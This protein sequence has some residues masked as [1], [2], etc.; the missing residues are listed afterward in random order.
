MQE[1]TQ[2]PKEEQGSRANVCSVSG[3]S[4]PLSP[5]SINAL[6]T[7]DNGDP[8]W[9]E[10]CQEDG[11]YCLY[12]EMDVETVRITRDLVS[13]LINSVDLLEIDF[14]GVKR[15]DSAG[16]ALL[17]E[18]VRESKKLKKEIRYYNIPEQLC[19]IARVSSLE[20]VLPLFR[21]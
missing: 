17:I 11:R 1:E 13:P 12:G 4:V 9:I 10:K 8:V 18:W 16:L 7:N 15:V 5:S 3:N 19:A 21:S 14:S 2:Q 20:L 6:L